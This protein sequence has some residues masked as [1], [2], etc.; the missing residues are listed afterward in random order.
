MPGQGGD[1]G[2]LMQSDTKGEFGW[3]KKGRELAFD[4]A[5][6]LAFLHSVGILHRQANRNRF[7]IFLGQSA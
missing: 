4:I 5:H 7:C 6:A 2:N 1:L 3:Y